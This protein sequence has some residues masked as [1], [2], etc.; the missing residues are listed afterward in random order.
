MAAP[1]KQGLDY[2][3]LDVNALKDRK[4]RQA[5]QKYGYLAN[6]VYLALL[7]LLYSDKGYFI[8]YSEDRQSDVQMDILD[9]LQGKYQPEQ[10]TIAD[11]IECLVACRLFSRDQFK[12]KKITSKRAQA[13]Y[14]RAVADRK[15]VDIDFDVWLLTESEMRELSVKCIIL[16]NFVNRTINPVNQAINPVNRAINPQSKGKE[17]K[18]KESIFAAFAAGA[19]L[20]ALKE[21]EQMRRAMKRPLDDASAKLL[22]KELDKLT[23]D[24]QTKIMIL[25]K[26]ILNGWPGVYQLKE[27]NQQSIT[28]ATG[29]SNFTQTDF[30]FKA[31]EDKSLK[32]GGV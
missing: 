27:Q 19:F 1:Y 32:R 11:V 18:G 9:F 20:E 23:N 12:R 24:E 4:L 2:F 13:T 14:Y 5:K 16:Q 3:P 26:S 30:D 7:C 28:K 29:F 31:I 6:D 25:E 15:M 21:F 8:D 17:R 10:R 22:L